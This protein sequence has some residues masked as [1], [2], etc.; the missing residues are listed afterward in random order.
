MI[1][2][3]PLTFKYQLYQSGDKVLENNMEIYRVQKNIQVRTRIQKNG[4]SMNLYIQR[5]YLNNLD[6]LEVEYEIEESQ[7]SING[8]FKV[9]LE[10]DQQVNGYKYRYIMPNNSS[11]N[12]PRGPFSSTRDNNSPRF[13]VII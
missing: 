10:F 1:F 4:L 7:K 11:V 6:E 8:Q 2:A 9:N 3:P 13:G 12:Q 5:T